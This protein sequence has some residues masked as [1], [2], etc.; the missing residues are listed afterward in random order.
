VWLIFVGFLFNYHGPS[1]G[2]SLCIIYFELCSPKLSIYSFDTIYMPATFCL[3]Y[4]ITWSYV[5]WFGNTHFMF[6]CCFLVGSLSLFYMEVWRTR[7]LI[8]QFWSDL[9]L[10]E[11]K[12]KL[13]EEYGHMKWMWYVMLLLLLSG[14]TDKGVI[15]MLWLHINV[16]SFAPHASCFQQ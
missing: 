15:H 10:K 9:L 5:S 8:I 2:Q 1:D 7:L 6:P 13:G 3:L 11:Q 4:G 12:I 14:C 16:N